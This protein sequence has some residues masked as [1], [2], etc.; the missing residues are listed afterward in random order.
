MI[1]C[2]PC[3]V[4]LNYLLQIGD[5]DL[6]IFSNHFKQKVKGLFGNEYISLKTLQ[7]DKFR[8]AV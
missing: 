4:K 2:I 3:E 6:S 8:R 7:I 5:K 1:C